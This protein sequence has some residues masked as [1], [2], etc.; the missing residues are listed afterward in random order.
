MSRAFFVLFL[1]LCL[2]T[3]GCGDQLFLER[4][5]IVLTLG[6]DLDEDNQ[7]LVYTT[8]PVFSKESKKKYDITAVKAPSLRQ[9]RVLLNSATPGHL[10]AGKTQNI[11]VGKRLLKKKYLFP[12]LDVYFRDAKNDFNAVMVGVDGPVKDIIYANMEEKGRIS[13]FIRDLID[14]TNAG[15][16]SV[17]TTLQQ[18]HY[19]TFEKGITPFFPEIRASHNEIIVAGTTLLNRHGR[20]A[21]TLS[22]EESQLLLLLQRNV[23]N[24]IPLFFTLPR[25][26]LTSKKE[27][28]E[29]SFNVDQVKYHVKTGY[30]NG[31]FTFDMQMKLR[32]SLT[33]RNF[34]INFEKQNNLLE[35]LLARE[36]KNRTEAL[37][38]KFQKHQLDPMGFGLYAQAFQY[39]HWNMVKE[40]WPKNLSQATI[41]I[42]PIVTIQSYGVE[43]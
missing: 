3:A 39:N 41:T 34:A 7:L 19:Q 4:A 11:L 5:S 38:K 15:G 42:S 6:V 37:V 26:K 16:G 14:T 31:R 33:E 22:R 27:R 32:V 43:M 36:L 40:D 24:T 23:R 12:I 9:A 18:F 2:V 13:M 35:S 10:V 21:T 8:T 1:S 17:R 28:T 20:Y 30:E 25:E 29:V